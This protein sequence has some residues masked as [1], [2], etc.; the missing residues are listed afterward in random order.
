MRHPFGRSVAPSACL[1][2]SGDGTAP[3]CASDPTMADTH[4]ANV[5]RMITPRREDC[6][7]RLVIAAGLYGTNVMS[8][9]LRTPVEYHSRT[10]Y[11]APGHFARPFAHEKSL[12]EAVTPGRTSARV[13]PRERSK[14]AKRRARE[15]TRT[16][17]AGEAAREGA[18][19]G[20]RGAKPLGVNMH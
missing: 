8:G 15:P 20:V 11:S 2:G 6:L 7:T 14:P 10:A 5:T 3:R 9:G 1:P 4:A 18:C 19:R 12:Q 13:S 17:Q 16:E